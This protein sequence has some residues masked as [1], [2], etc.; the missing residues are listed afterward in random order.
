MR[1]VSVVGSSGSGKS[2]V[3]ARLAEQLGVPHTELDA[4]NH[5]PNWTPLPP[6]EFRRHVTEITAAA[7][8]V[9]DGN[10][11]TVRDIVWDRADTVV[12]LDLP[13]GLVARRITMR[14]IRRVVR[15]E[16]LWNGNRER[17]RN[18]LTRDPEESAI[19]HSWQNHQKNHDRYA[20]AATIP[21]SLSCTSCNSD[22]NARSTRSSPRH[23][24]ATRGPTS[25]ARWRRS[26]TRRRSCGRRIGR[27]S[28]RIRDMIV[29][30]PEWIAD[31]RVRVA[32][33][34]RPP[35]RVLRGAAARNGDRE[36][37]GLFVAPAVMRQGIGR[38]LI[39]DATATA[40]AQGATRVV[41]TANLRAQ[42]FYERCGFVPGG[43]VPTRFEPG[44]PDAPR[45]PRD[46]SRWT[47][48]PASRTVR[49][50]LAPDEGIAAR[51]HDAVRDDARA[52]TWTRW[53]G[54]LNH[55]FRDGGKPFG[56]VRRHTERGRECA[57]GR[58][59]RDG[60]VRRRDRTGS[61]GERAG[62]GHD[63][64][65]VGTPRAELH[66]GVRRAVP[67]RLPHG[68]PV[69]R[70]P[71]RGRRRCAGGVRPRLPAVVAARRSRGLGRRA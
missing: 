37:D 46:D 54:R 14:S 49:P 64:S 19:R 29:V 60:R 69:A 36:L 2:T 53:G 70:R 24:Y 12:W 32:D 40:W 58:S 18:L 57:G 33:A 61:H 28:S 50:R 4:I 38:L 9:V 27:S 26:S 68:L 55:L 15:R 22:R 52:L 66:R 7:Q 51:V 62:R 67:R 5:Q 56:V 11:S 1:R 10:Y 3:A 63:H 65:E 43:L 48:G 21:P 8:W 71:P 39:E 34:A 31:G 23:A 25:K 41:V 59:S 44:P 17:L 16:E 20:A 30:E 42:G 13:R 35:A 45:S 6:D 47:A